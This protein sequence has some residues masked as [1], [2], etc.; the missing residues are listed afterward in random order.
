MPFIKGQSGNPKGRPLGSKHKLSESFLKALSDD[1]EVHGVDAI[2]KV[3]SEKP[4]AYLRIVADLVPKD[5]NITVEQ[6]VARVPDIAAT[7]DEWLNQN[8]PAKTLQ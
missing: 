5:V 8:A 4:D 2:I 3:R 1:F 6:F 7:T